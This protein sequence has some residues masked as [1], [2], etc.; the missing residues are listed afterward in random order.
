[1]PSKAFV[2]SLESSFFQFLRHL[3][4]THYTEDH[5]LHAVALSSDP[6]ILFWQAMRAPDTDKFKASMIKEFQDHCN[7]HHWGFV[8]RSFLP[9]GTKVLPSVWPMKHRWQITMR[10]VYQ[11]KSCL[12]VHGGR[13]EF[14]TGKPTLPWCN[15]VQSYLLSFWHWSM[16]GIPVKWICP[17]ILHLRKII[18]SLHEHATRI[19]LQ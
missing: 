14:I 8:P 4:Q 3:L 11:W 13:R 9:P 18:T 10:D 2:E 15:G 16:A 19:Y 17:T 12:T 7:K 5:S 1:M 6:D